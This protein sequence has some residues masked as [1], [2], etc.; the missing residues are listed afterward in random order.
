MNAEEIDLLSDGASMRDFCINLKHRS[1][2]YTPPYAR[3]D[4]C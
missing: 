2:A 1:S 3:G 4:L